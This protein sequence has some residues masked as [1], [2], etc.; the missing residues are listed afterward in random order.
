[1]SVL[2][3]FSAVAGH[4]L[5]CRFGHVF[6]WDSGSSVGDISGHTKFINSIDYRPVRPFRV[7]TAGEDN[8]VCWFEGPPFRYKAIFKVCKWTSKVWV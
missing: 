5:L 2:L 3:Y 1:M 8:A 7:A 6:L 4:F